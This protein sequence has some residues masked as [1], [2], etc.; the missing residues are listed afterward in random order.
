MAG[1]PIESLEELLRALGRERS[2]R[3]RLRVLGH[4]WQLLR[5]LRP[6]EREKVALRLGS[7]W[8]WQRLEKSF[9]RDGDLDDTE[10]LVGRVLERLGDSDPSELRELASQVRRGDRQGTQ[11]LLLLTLREALEEEASSDAAERMLGSE[12]DTASADPEAALE[13]EPELAPEPTLGVEPE[14]RP[15]AETQEHVAGEPLV[16]DSVGAV[17]ASTLA[18]RV[19]KPPADLRPAADAP[20]PAPTG[21]GRLAEAP[22]QAHAASLPAL[23]LAGSG[24]NS[25]RMLR[26]L[27]ADPRAGAALGREGRQ[28]LLDSLGGG[29]AS[30]RALSHW[31]ESGA[32]DDV[33]E[34]LGLIHSLSRAGQRTWCLADLIERGSLA[35]PELERV[36]AAVPTPG[37]RRRLA[38]RAAERPLPD[39]T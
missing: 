32:L 20:S 38:R 39:P 15:S 6:D 22:P 2:L 11:D 27:R 9:L 12:S 29:W 18:R 33:D 30:R 25:L 3:G 26:S 4:S 13:A 23:P 1:L 36:L 5:R 37:A 24:V 14:P 16:V 35:A 21:R 31:I 17:L 7:R 8:A 10:Q 28:Q 19:E 34:A